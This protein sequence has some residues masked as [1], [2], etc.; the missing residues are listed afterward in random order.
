MSVV[1]SFSS[2]VEYPIF[3]DLWVMTHEQP[4]HSNPSTSK[5]DWTWLLQVLSFCFFFF[6]FFDEWQRKL[7]MVNEWVESGDKC[8]DLGGRGR[9]IK[10]KEQ[11]VIGDQRIDFYKHNTSNIVLCRV[12]ICNGNREE[13]AACPRLDRNQIFHTQY[14]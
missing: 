9:C 3:L 14:Y 8:E 11:L 6:K 13:K 4:F 2:K 12:P 1:L 7:L 5:H 10:H